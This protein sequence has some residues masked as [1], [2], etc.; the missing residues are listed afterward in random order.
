MRLW[1]SFLWY[2]R[3]VSSDSVDEACRS[4]E[5][6]EWWQCIASKTESLIQSSS[7][8]W[9]NA[10]ST[11][12]SI[13][14]WKLLK[15]VRISVK[16]KSVSNK[17]SGVHIKN[18][19]C[20]LRPYLSP[21]ILS[22][23]DCDDLV[24]GPRC[25][26]MRSW[27]MRSDKTSST[28]QP[29]Q[30]NQEH[31]GVVNTLCVCRRMPWFLADDS[32]ISISNPLIGIRWSPEP[33]CFS[34]LIENIENRSRLRPPR[35]QNCLRAA[36]MRLKVMTLRIWR[37]KVGWVTPQGFHLWFHTLVERMW[38]VKYASC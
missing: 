24:L 5:L 18:L 3:C 17:V 10:L 37:K 13:F 12:W 1:K 19:P 7:T 4:F 28:I 20:H 8:T 29:L 14:H 30:E 35:G 26:V 33:N 11:Y 22:V 32:T 36:M 9:L 34:W 38:S 23:E 21:S 16:M 6:A 2:I 31:Q 25:K 27:V 15:R